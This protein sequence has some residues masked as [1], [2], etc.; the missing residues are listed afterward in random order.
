MSLVGPA[1]G[2]GES[3]SEL[4]EEEE[5]GEVEDDDEEE[6]EGVGSQ[7]IRFPWSSPETIG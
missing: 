5:D 2:V 4:E 3:Y 7:K 1:G 6:V